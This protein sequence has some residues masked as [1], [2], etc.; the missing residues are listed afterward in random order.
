MR[1]TRNTNG[2]F[3]GKCDRKRPLGIHRHSWRIILKWILKRDN[4][5]RCGLP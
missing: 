1:K 4:V 3:V 5:P 2:I